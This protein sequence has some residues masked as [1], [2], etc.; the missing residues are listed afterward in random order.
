MVFNMAYRWPIPSCFNMAY[1][2]PIADGHMTYV[3]IQT[4]MQ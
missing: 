1:I 3:Q 4:V 2:W